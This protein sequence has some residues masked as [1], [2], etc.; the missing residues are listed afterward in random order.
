MDESSVKLDFKN[1]P[2]TTKYKWVGLP[3]SAAVRLGSVMGKGTTDFPMGHKAFKPPG[4]TLLRKERPHM[5]GSPAV[6]MG[7]AGSLSIFSQGLSIDND[8]HL[9]QGSPRTI[10]GSARAAWAVELSNSPS[11]RKADPPPEGMY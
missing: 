7:T 5:S 4:N 9:R 1:F 3:G 10:G 11:L 8:T 2:Q 6:G